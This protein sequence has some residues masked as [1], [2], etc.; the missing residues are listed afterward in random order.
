LIA[1]LGST[2]TPRK[3]RFGLVDNVI[4]PPGMLTTFCGWVRICVANVLKFPPVGDS[5]TAGTLGTVKVAMIEL[6]SVKLLVS[7]STRSTVTGPES[8]VPK[9]SSTI[10]GEIVSPACMWEGTAR[11]MT[12]SSGNGWAAT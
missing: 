2:T 5:E 12:R 1:P 6:P 9:F 7:D 11:P 8:A 10:V 3:K 4:R